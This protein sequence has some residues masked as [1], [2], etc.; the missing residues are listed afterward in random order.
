VPDFL[1]PRKEDVINCQLWA[2][3]SRVRALVQARKLQPDIDDKV[4]SSPKKEWL[5]DVMNDDPIELAIAMTSEPRV[6][7]LRTGR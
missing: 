7:L 1:D 3:T 4:S 5:C 2:S 6:M